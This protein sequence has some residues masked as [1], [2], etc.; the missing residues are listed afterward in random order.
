MRRVLIVLDC[1]QELPSATVRGMGYQELFAKRGEWA[2]EYASRRSPFM[3]KVLRRGHR[4]SLEFAVQVCRPALNRI[5]E[6]MIRR[7]EDRI[8]ERAAGCD[9]VYTLKIPSWRLHQK[10]AN[11]GGTRLVM[12]LNDGVWLPAFVRGGWE[13]L[14]EMLRTAHGV[15]CDND[16]VAG[17]AKRHNP[18]VFVVPDPAQVECFDGWRAGV[19]RDSSRVVVGWIGSPATAGSLHAI[20]EPLEGLFERH[21]HLHLRIIGAD[22]ESLP[23]FEKVRWSSVVSYDQEVMIREALAMDI[24]LFPMFDVEDSLARGTLKAQIYMSAEMA[25]IASRIGESIRLI[26]DGENGMLAAGHAE[27]LEKLEWL[28]THPVERAVMAR[29]GLE[30]VRERFPLERC[31]DALM[32]AFDGVCADGARCG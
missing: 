21:S 9:V 12:D 32:S 13:H 10:L 3:S 20:W 28:V 14:S 30:T 2:V 26:R 6:E 8:A 16:Y 31:F 4:P 19:R 25:V 22:R 27:W 11:L 18:R 29:R 15:V 7:S 1:G 23:R 5:N 24:G 17:Y